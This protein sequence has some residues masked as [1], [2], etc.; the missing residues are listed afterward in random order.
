MKTVIHN[1]NYWWGHNQTIITNDGSGSIRVSYV[2][3]D[4]NTAF[5]DNLIV[6]KQKRKQG[7]G[8]RLM[9]IANMCAIDNNCNKIKLWTQ[10][11]TDWLVSWYKRLG[12]VIDEYYENDYVFQMIKNL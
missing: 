3:D 4:P 12:F 9:N 2:D 8:T 10:K 7:I 5:V 6:L 11:D 1:N